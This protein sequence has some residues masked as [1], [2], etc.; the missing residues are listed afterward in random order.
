ML[1][2]IQLGSI[3]LKRTK[4]TQINANKF[5]H[6]EMGPSVT[7]PNPENC[8]NCSSMCAYQYQIILL[9]YRVTCLWTT[10]PESLHDSETTRS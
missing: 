2:I 1:G 6:S 7:K 10:C 4:Y 9:G 3:K 5:T 8:K